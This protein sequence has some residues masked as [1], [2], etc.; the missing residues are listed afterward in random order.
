[1]ECNLDIH[2]GSNEYKTAM[3]LAINFSKHSLALV[4]GGAARTLSG[5]F[6]S[7]MHSFLTSCWQ[8]SFSALISG[9]RFFEKKNW[10]AILIMDTYRSL[11]NAWIFARPLHC[12]DAILENYT[13][14]N[15]KRFSWINPIS[16][17]LFIGLLHV[18]TEFCVFHDNVERNNRR[19]I[20]IGVFHFIQSL[21]D[22]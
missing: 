21:V 14:V 6:Q 15:E 19:H 9:E 8:T 4:F 7:C 1:M 12:S 18:G 2:K 17:L 22:G 11:E 16:K 10:I 20:V 13:A 3:P 5:T